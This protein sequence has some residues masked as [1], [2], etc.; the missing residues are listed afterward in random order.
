MFRGQINPVSNYNVCGITVSDI[1]YPTSEHAYQHKK[2]VEM[3]D[4][5]LAHKILNTPTPQDPKYYGN[6][7]RTNVYWHS[8]KQ[9]V[10]YGIIQ[11]KVNQCTEFDQRLV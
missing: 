5:E 3:N 9:G 1:W 7:L 2:A 10:M 11:V 6:Q 8:I 4:V